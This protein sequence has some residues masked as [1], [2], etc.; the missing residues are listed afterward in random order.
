[1]TNKLV[2]MPGDRVRL[3]NIRTKDFNITGTVESQRVTIDD[4]IVSYNI[5]MD[6]GYPTTRHRRFLRPL[7]TAD[8][9][10][11]TPDPEIP[12]DGEEII[13]NLPNSADTR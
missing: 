9:K 5:Q 1:M 10:E 11:C 8:P 6:K 7:V 12:K 2:Y 3:Q 13:D 4:Q